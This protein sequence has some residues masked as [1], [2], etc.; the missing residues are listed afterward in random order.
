MRLYVLSLVFFLLA[1][2]QTAEAI[3]ANTLR[4]VFIPYEKYTLP[5]GLEVILSKDIRSASV[6]FNI[7]YKVGAIYEKPSKTGLAH[8]FEH[9][10]FEGSFHVPQDQHFKLL[11][12]VN[13]TD[14][15]ASTSYFFTNY[16]ETLSSFNI[17]L[18]FWLESSRMSFLQLSES[19]RKE[20][21]AVVKRE[22][23]VRYE[24]KPYALAYM[25]FWQSLFSKNDPRYGHVIGSHEDLQNAT[26]NDLQD[27]YNTYYG[28]SNACLTIV[29][30]FDSAK[31]KELVNKYFFTLPASK[32]S[33][34]PQIKPVIFNKNETIYY[35]DK[36]AKTSLIKKLYLSPA[37]FDKGDAEM[38]IIAHILGNG[39][40]SRLYNILVR[41]K[42][43]AS[44][45]SAYQQS[46][47]IQSF[48]YIEAYP[49]PGTDNKYFSDE[50]DKIIKNI[51]KKGF[52]QA[53]LD[54]ARNAILTN[55]LF[56]L[57]KINNK[58]QM[59]QSYNLYTNDPGFIA[60]DLNRYYSL[61]LKDIN[62]YF[63]K[64]LSNS[65]NKTL[66]VTP[67]GN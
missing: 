46:M 32:K 55:F 57:Q 24:T 15:N 31:I 19:K 52:T 6:A 45:V 48:F 50:L 59:L 4:K 44:S 36:L 21:L 64:V 14:I 42:K 5:N 35:D 27:F 37:L 39:Q 8:L 54:R 56:S 67:K 7:T 58:A 38:D 47:P 9:L 34:L 22:R 65:F 49:M 43:V 1:K 66:I 61:T 23:E 62:E 10:M 41:D 40:F 11:E 29:G 30:N 16:Y 17:E 3:K 53:E 25:F 26:V 13:A 51:A 20:Q 60:K 28:P 63:V 33:S 2:N 12:K 18:A